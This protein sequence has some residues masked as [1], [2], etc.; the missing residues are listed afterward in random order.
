MTLNLSRSQKWMEKA[1]KLM[2][3]G[4]NSPV[5]AFGAVG[6]EPP[7]IK[8]AK[9]AYL[10][11]EDDNQYI[12]Y[13]GSWGPMILGH[14]HPAV[15]AAIQE[16]AAHGTSYGA[17]TANEVRLA[18]KIRDFFPSMEM[19]RL[20]NSGTEA[21]MS[22]IRLARAATARPKIVKFAGCYHGHADSFLIAAGS[23]ATTLGIPSSPGVTPGTA[24]DTLLANYNDLEG[25]RRLFEVHP[26][27]IAAVIIEPIPG[28][29]GLIP[30]HE[31]FLEGLR[32]LTQEQGAL[33]IFDEVMTG[34]RVAPGGVQELYGIEP[35]L[36][37][38][39]KVI[40]GGLPV[41]AYGGKR[42][43]MEQIAPS[44]PVYQAGT[45]SG[46]PLAVAAGLSTLS[47][48]QEEGVYDRLET[49]CASLE[50]GIRQNLAELS[51]P[52][53]VTRFGSM[54]CL[55]LSEEKV[56][57][58]DSAKRSDTARFARYFQEMLARG[59]YLPASQFEALFVSTAH[60]QDDVAKTLQANREALST[61]FS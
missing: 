4:V 38:L 30:P 18:E 13:V 23:G 16:A 54:L 44:G 3:G 29:M 47:L 57:D 49:I 25:V 7:W 11:D 8:R 55:F 34:F 58:Y 56:F 59:I 50:D 41:G 28:N 20:V 5:R 1:R 36:T 12:D 21:C 35:D 2:P 40:G 39:G 19:M 52:L 33:L 53:F 61:A 14:A 15:I 51:L 24:A 9:G 17:P 37:T 32:A 42:R 10:W 27:Q 6:G 31:G 26:E 46:N 22:V 45:L 48:L 43:W 60:S